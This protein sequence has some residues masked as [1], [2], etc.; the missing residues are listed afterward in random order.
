MGGYSNSS[1]SIGGHMNG[2]PVTANTVVTEAPT[3][4][5][6]VNIRD[7]EI[8]E[9]GE[10]ACASGVHQFSSS[11]LAAAIAALDDPAI[12]EPRLKLGHVGAQGSMLGQP[13]FGKVSG[14]RLQSEGNRINGDLVGLPD[15]LAEIL[16]T[17]Y[18]SRSIE[19]RWNYTSASGTTH[20]FVILSVSLLGIEMPGC[21]TL[22]DLQ[23]YYANGPD[24]VEVEAE[25]ESHVVAT[26]NYDR[27]DGVKHK[28][29]S[30]AVEPHQVRA[31]FYDE[32]AVG[33]RFMWWVHELF[34]NPME[35]IAEDE[36]NS[37]FHRIP[38]NIGTDDTVT[39][40]DPVEVKKE[41]VPVGGANASAGSDPVLKYS[42]RAESRNDQE[43]QEM[44]LSD[45]QKATLRRTLGL[46]EDATDEQIQS[47]LGE[48]PS[49]PTTDPATP[50]PESE[51]TAPASTPTTPEPVAASTPGTVVFDA[52]TAA[53]MQADAAAGRAA[54]DE[55]ITAR[56]DALVNA[57]I[58]DGRIPPARFDH[59]RKLVDLDE[60]GTA[61]TLAS[62]QKGLIPVQERGS[63]KDS[64][65]ASAGADDSSAYP[66]WLVP[67]GAANTE[68]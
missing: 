48:A 29:V 30:A 26:Y 42:T 36:S 15:W 64:S 68:G 3:Q 8:L 43:D 39:F 31:Q 67:S 58:D 50:A 65:G 27:E 51:S 2:Q 56:R 11:D 62:L 54:R 23:H 34:I 7:V 18:P 6:L 12:H 40:G 59:Y 4:I 60:E 37:S 32:F 20:Q 41:Y 17:A 57:A 63:A 9:T 16:P 38:Y 1:Y 66:D 22:E 21:A 49:V 33:D 19:G 35:I 5:K 44:K 10:F 25:E 61:A 52:A 46:P 28:K 13:V 24:G 53:Q 47:K 14:M 55:Q 45:E